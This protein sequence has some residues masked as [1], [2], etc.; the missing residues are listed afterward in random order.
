MLTSL[1]SRE[2]V[3]GAVKKLS[4]SFPNK[5]FMVQRIYIPRRID[6]PVSTPCVKRQPVFIDVIN[7]RQKPFSL[8]VQFGLKH[9][10]WY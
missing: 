7:G 3:V 5:A 8:C 9:N 4:T 10:I 6:H 2:L 1:D